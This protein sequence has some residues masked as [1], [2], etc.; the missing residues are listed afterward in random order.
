M[1]TT[2][3]MGTISKALQNRISREKL[4][5]FLARFGANEGAH[6]YLISADILP[7]D[8]SSE[9]RKNLIESYQSREDYEDL[10]E[11]F[12]IFMEEKRAQEQ[13]QKMQ[14]NSQDSKQN[15]QHNLH[16]ELNEEELFYFLLEH[17]NTE[18]L[19][20]L[21]IALYDFYY[22]SFLKSSFVGDYII[23]QCTQENT[24]SKTD[25]KTQTSPKH[26]QTRFY[27]LL[28]C[29]ERYRAL[30]QIKLSQIVRNIGTESFGIFSRKDMK[31]C[32]INFAESKVNYH[33][34]C[35]KR[36]DFLLLENGT[37]SLKNFIENLI[38]LYENAHINK[39]KDK[40]NAR[41]DSINITLNAYLLV[42]DF[43]LTPTQNLARFYALSSIPG[44]FSGG[45]GYMVAKKRGEEKEMMRD[46]IRYAR[47]IPIPHSAW[48]LHCA[49]MQVYEDSK[50]NIIHKKAIQGLKHAMHAYLSSPLLWQDVESINEIY[51]QKA[52]DIKEEMQEKTEAEKL[53][54]KDIWLEKSK[55]HI[56]VICKD[57]EQ[58]EA[59]CNLQKLG[60]E[61][62]DNLCVPL[63]EKELNLGQILHKVGAFVAKHYVKNNGTLALRGEIWSYVLHYQNQQFHFNAKGEL[64]KVTP[65]TGKGEKY[66]YLSKS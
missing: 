58:D 8:V 20:L 62:F 64:T 43:K 4:Q 51:M 35:S 50:Q 16:F 55:H 28:A 19:K 38:S 6:F 3:Q 15:L 22:H 27:I 49:A 46:F 34:L 17:K 45:Y 52:L 40:K 30:L 29:N 32:A 66:I 57:L 5:D 13:A 23:L 18:R 24:K 54:E 14:E 9:E 59:Y 48:H 39:E 7:N 41:L 53:Q 26:L 44:G 60:I 56:E 25:S 47:H 11:E 10:L 63:G 36:N 42:R 2:T 21:D 37:I 31:I 61:S 1:Q 65:N 12:E 33:Y